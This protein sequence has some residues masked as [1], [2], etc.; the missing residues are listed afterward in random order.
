MSTEQ[1]QRASVGRWLAINRVLEFI[2]VSSYDGE[3]PGGDGEREDGKTSRT[4][5]WLLNSS[6]YRLQPLPLSL[7][8]T[9]PL[10]L[11]LN[12]TPTFFP[13]SFLLNEQSEIKHNRSNFGSNF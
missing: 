2:I 4:A 6:I 13:I 8:F 7:T 5:L 12:Q 3:E 10:L 11:F 1:R 9:H